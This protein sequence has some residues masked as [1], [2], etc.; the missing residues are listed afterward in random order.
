[1]PIAESA[2]ELWTIT[3]RFVT[4]N[5]VR[6]DDLGATPTKGDPGYD[7]KVYMPDDAPVKEGMDLKVPYSDDT[8]HKTKL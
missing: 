4:C 8:A 2:K 3:T 7:P 1:M 5:Q 6:P